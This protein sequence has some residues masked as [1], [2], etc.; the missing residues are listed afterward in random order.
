MMSVAG[1]K[2]ER[3]SDHTRS[4][5]NSPH[6]KGNKRNWPRRWKI[7]RLTHR[8]VSAIND[9]F[10]VV[11]HDLARLTAEWKSVTATVSAP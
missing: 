1:P 5:C 2:R 3:I 6:W 4:K 9:D 7:Q 11:S 8:A 10:S